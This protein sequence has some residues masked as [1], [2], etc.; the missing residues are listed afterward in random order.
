MENYLPPHSRLD[1]R[2]EPSPLAYA[3]GYIMPPLSWLKI[4]KGCC[5]ES[6]PFPIRFFA[7]QLP[8]PRTKFEVEFYIWYAAPGFKLLELSA[9]Y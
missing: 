6:P 1:V 3:S 7:P 5:F 8:S 2:L 4:L 9:G